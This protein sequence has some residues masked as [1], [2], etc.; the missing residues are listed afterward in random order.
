MDT[1][2]SDD[3]IA[4]LQIR[5]EILMLFLAFLLWPDQQKLEDDGHERERQQGR[6]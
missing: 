5:E 4:G 1:A 6:H 2:A 3:F